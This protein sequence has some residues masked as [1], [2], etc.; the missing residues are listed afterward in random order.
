MKCLYDEIRHNASIV[1]P[2][3]WTKRIEDADNPRVQTMVTMIGHS[4]G[5]GV[6]FCF[7]INAPWADR[8]YVAPIGFRLWVDERVSIDLR[9][10]CEQKSSIFLFG[11]SQDFMC[12]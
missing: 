10:T 4:H 11:Q 9:R 7:I 6:S 1:W 12:P 2:H 8:I 3:S 5:F